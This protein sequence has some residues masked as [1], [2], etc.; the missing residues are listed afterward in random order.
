MMTRVGRLTDAGRSMVPRCGDS[1][2]RSLR[3]HRDSHRRGEGVEGFSSPG[4]ATMPGVGSIGLFLS[5]VGVSE[6]AADEQHA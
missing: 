5:E 4:S 2:V 3:V 1:V 6:P